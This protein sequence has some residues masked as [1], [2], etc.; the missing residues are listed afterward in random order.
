MEIGLFDLIKFAALAICLIVSFVLSIVIKIQVN[1]KLPEDERFSWWSRGRFGV[2][3]MHREL[4]PGSLL[5]DIAQGSF[6]LGLL[7]LAAIVVS[8]ISSESE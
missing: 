4:F 1:R 2:Y 3:G 6:W 8:E 7:L 5:A